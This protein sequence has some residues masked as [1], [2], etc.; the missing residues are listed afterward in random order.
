MNR[1]QRCAVYLLQTQNVSVN[2]L[3]PI[4]LAWGSEGVAERQSK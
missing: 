3:S 1:A 4:W 2:S